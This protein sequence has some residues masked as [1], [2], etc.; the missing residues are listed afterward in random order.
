M[1]WKRR[2]GV[3]LLASAALLGAN[4]GQTASLA[5]N[6]PCGAFTGLQNWDDGDCYM[7]ITFFENG[8][9]MQYHSCREHPVPENFCTCEP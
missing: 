5:Y 9:C 1:N 3:A 4:L 6:P 7:T 8:S 2:F